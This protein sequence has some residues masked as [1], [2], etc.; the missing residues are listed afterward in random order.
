MLVK[1]VLPEHSWATKYL[2]G[3]LGFERRTLYTEIISNKR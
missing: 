1:I 3:I 2:K